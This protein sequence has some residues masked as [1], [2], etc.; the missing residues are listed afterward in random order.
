MLNNIV[1]FKVYYLSFCHAFV[2]GLVSG[3]GPKGDV[4]EPGEK[5]CVCVCVCACV[6]VCVCV[7]FM[8]V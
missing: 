2:Q 6:C 1:V 7:M 3:K 5:V 4:G 8:V